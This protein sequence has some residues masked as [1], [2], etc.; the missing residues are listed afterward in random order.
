LWRY[1]Q[2]SE[3]SSSH[4]ATSA[5]GLLPA[6]GSVDWLDRRVEGQLW[7][8]AFYKSIDTILWGRKTC[9]MALE[10][11]KKAIPGAESIPKVKTMSSHAVPYHRPYCG[12]KLWTNQI[13]FVA[14]AREKGKD[15]G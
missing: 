6:D 11:Q 12:V 1:G 4:I 13:K 15:I 2:Q 8:T 3:R 5:D 14:S 7:M 10:F 9:E